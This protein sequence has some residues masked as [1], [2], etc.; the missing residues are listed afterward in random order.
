[1]MQPPRQH[2]IPR[3]APS[4]F[5]VLL[6]ASLSY[7]VIQSIVRSNWA[8]GLG[9]LVPVALGGVLVAALFAHLRW[10]PSWLAHL[11]TA[12]LGIAWTVARVGPLMGAG[13][14]TW[15]DQATELLICTIMLGRLVSQGGTGDDLLLFVALLGLLAWALAY[16][17]VWM[18]VRY[19]WAWWVVLINAILLFVNL[20]YASPK[21]PIGLFFLFIG[22]ALLV[23]VQQNFRHRARSWDAAQMEYPDL[24]GWRFVGSGVM[25]VLVMLVSTTLLPTTITTARVA[26]VWQ[27][28]REPW[29]QVQARWDRTFSNINA[30]ANAAGGGFS[31]KNF[32]LSGART[33]GDALVMEVQASRFDYW[34]AVALDRYNGGLSW[35]NTTGDLARATLGRPTDEEAL[36]PLNSG[37]SMPLLD[38]TDRQP[39]TQTFTLRQNFSV[40]T[41]FA[42]TQPVSLTLPTLVQHTY[43]SGN[44]TAVANFTDM[45]MLLAQTPLRNGASYTVLSLASNADKTSL[46]AASTDYSPWVQRYLQLPDSLPPRVAAK[47]AELVAAA[48]AQNP[49]DKAAAIETFLRTFPYDE[50][51]PSP[52][53]DRDVIDYFVFDLKRGYCDYFASSMVILL[54]TQGVPARVA[55]GYAGGEYNAQ[56]GRF[57]VRQNLAHTWPE[58]YF[59]GYGWQRFE[60]TPA[61]YTRPPTRPETPD[62]SR[63]GSP[64]TNRLNNRD[65]EEEDLIEKERLA[66]EH[67]GQPFTPSQAQNAIDQRQ[68]ELAAAQ[69]VLWQRRGVVGTGA[70]LAL[71]AGLW[72]LRRREVLR[73]AAQSYARLLRWARW[74]GIA[75]RLSATPHEVAATVARYLPEQRPALDTLAAAFTREQYAPNSAPAAE[76]LGAWRTLRWP[77][78]GAVFNRFGRGGP[79]QPK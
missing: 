34:R 35:S 15:R 64:V 66:A 13:L 46:R 69:R 31:G 48:N 25:V 2:W 42:A 74:A 16:S 44:G 53:D 59:P 36:T 50:K 55:Q 32:T 5:T 71:L 61:S 60:P 6:G 17:S 52:P 68:V 8:A 14:P 4:L 11:L 78:V 77:L 58:V 27:R 54:R 22:A 21:P 30:P 20:T 72:T 39:V 24:L 62:A 65:L 9:L 33:L 63:A 43:L 47:A 12:A 56:T 38:I 79:R 23:I 49:Y 57:E 75:P 76:V 73:P 40:P 51:I 26:H 1:M 41:I 29:Q 70:A 37:V 3:Y 10:M 45:S 19:G 7:A 67:Q 28:V 18:L